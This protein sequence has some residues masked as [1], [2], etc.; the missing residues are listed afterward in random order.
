MFYI[1]PYLRIFDFLWGCCV[2]HETEYNTPVPAAEIITIGTEI[3][4]GEIVD[5]NSRHI[6]RALRDEGIDLYWTSTVGD[7]LERIAEALR[8]GMA[9]SEIIIAT[10][11]LG[12]TVD[13]PTREAVARAIGVEAE[14][15]EER[16]QQVVDRFA[17]FGRTPTD[18]NRRQAYIPQGAIAIENPVGTAP[19]FIVETNTTVIIALPGV[20]REMEHLMQH[21][22]L[23][24]LRERFE[25]KGIIKAR[26]LH[27]AGAGESQIDERIGDLETESNPTVGLSA[28]AGQVDV[29]IT[30]KADSEEEANQLIASVEAELRERLGD[31]IY[32]ADEDT[33]EGSALENVAKKGWKLVVVEAGLSGGLT[34]RLVDAR[35]SFFK[36]GEVLPRSPGIE[37]LEEICRQAMASK[38]ADA[39][40]GVSLHTGAEKQDLHLVAITP[41][42]ARAFSRS[43]GGP[44][45]MAPRWAV[46]LCLNYIR[47]WS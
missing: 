35:N 41:V 40:L 31:W 12:P 6:A 44:P 27:T 3:L 19:A 24:Y 37:E 33:L 47:T 36:G 7:N 43:Y 2:F 5:T 34:Q 29:R 21:D 8:A 39:C 13:D 16:W 18:N 1:L 9:R 22:I 23:P 46:S 4:L 10:G 25:L 38:S 26:I 15:R 17:R 14:F 11:G 45:L 28:H 32:G 20:P 30:A 42:K